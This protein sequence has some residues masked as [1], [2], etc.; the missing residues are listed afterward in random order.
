MGVLREPSR[1]FGAPGCTRCRCRTQVR[2]V[3]F[4]R[5]APWPRAPQRGSGA[6]E[7]NHFTRIRDDAALDVVGEAYRQENVLA[8]RPPGQGD[9]PPGLPTPPAGYYSTAR[10][11]RSCANG[12]SPGPR[13]A[14]LAAMP[15]TW[16]LAPSAWRLRR[17]WPA[18]TT[19][20]TPPGSATRSRVAGST[21]W[22]PS[23]QMSAIRGLRSEARSVRSACRPPRRLV[24]R[25]HPLRTGR[26]ALI[27]HRSDATQACRVNR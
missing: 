23:R 10:S 20:L 27:D 12:A 2:K 4:L 3:S 13:T 25:V 6:G 18:A 26:S 24:G 16:R 21:R 22:N 5:R 8:A 1:T 17:T 7:V 9:L 15:S 14:R 19:G 11:S